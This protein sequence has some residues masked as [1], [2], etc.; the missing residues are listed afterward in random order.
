MPGPV[1][2]LQLRLVSFLSVEPPITRALWV[3]QCPRQAGAT[4]G[5]LVLGEPVGASAQEG[6]GGHRCH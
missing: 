2:R 1:P 4:L 6:A 3:Q 5:P